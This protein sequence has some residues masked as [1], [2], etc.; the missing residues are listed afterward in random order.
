[1]QPNAPAAVALQDTSR[2][3][4][5]I[6]PREA[7]WSTPVLPPSRRAI[8]PLRRDGGWRFAI[9]QKIRRISPELFCANDN[10][11]CHGAAKKDCRFSA[12]ADKYG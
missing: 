4:G 1:L 6:V 12:P 7:S 11:N 8:A 3:S 5:I 9:K 10:L 2:I